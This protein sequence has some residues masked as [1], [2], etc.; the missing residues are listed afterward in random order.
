[1][2]ETLKTQKNK[3]GTEHIRLADDRQMAYC[4][5]GDPGGKPVFYF[6]GIAV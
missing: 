1:V 5:Y 3:P 6:H 4:E 2:E